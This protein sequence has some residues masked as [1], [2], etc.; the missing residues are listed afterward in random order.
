MYGSVRSEFGRQKSQ[1]STSIGRSRWMMLTGAPPAVLTHGSFVGN[2]GAAIVSTGARI[3]VTRGPRAAH[4]ADLAS[5]AKAGKDARSVV[6]FARKRPRTQPDAGHRRQISR[7][8]R[9]SPAE[10]NG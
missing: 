9:P 8:S 3:S 7:W 10:S 5:K 1:N 4:N 6:C 2:S